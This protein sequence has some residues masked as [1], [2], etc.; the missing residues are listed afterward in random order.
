MKKTM[1]FSLFLFCL[2][3]SAI[4][5]SESGCLCSNPNNKGNYYPFNAFKNIYCYFL[6]GDF[7]HGSNMSRQ[8]HNTSD[9]ADNWPLLTSLLK[10]WDAICQERYAQAQ[11]YLDAAERTLSGYQKGNNKSKKEYNFLLTKGYLGCATGI[12]SNLEVQLEGK[13]PL[14]IQKLKELDNRKQALE[15][16]I[17]PTLERDSAALAREIDSLRQMKQKIEAFL[18]QPSEKLGSEIKKLNA[19]N[20]SLAREVAAREN[21]LRSVRKEL[22]AEKQ[23]V[24]QLDQEMNGLSKKDSS[25]IA[26]DYYRLLAER[27]SLGNIVISQWQVIAFQQE[28]IKRLFSP[29]TL[30]AAA[31]TVFF[32]SNSYKVSSKGLRR[33]EN[34]ARQIAARPNC[35]VLLI[36]FADSRGNEGFNKRLA[37]YRLDEVRYM[38]YKNGVNIMKIATDNFG[39]TGMDS[40]L[41]SRRVEIYVICDD[42]EA[43]PA[44]KVKARP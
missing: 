2:T 16:A 17:I 31:D 4:E 32:A 8:L 26:R 21:E 1:L 6:K 23:K 24:A 27:D 38:L 35:K 33:L 9:R 25:G 10:A 37:G 36:G 12:L 29:P 18:N 20:D 7:T 13:V 5:A 41:K 11:A 40:S 39:K 34:L 19:R 14:V 42:S 22:Q 43:N 3:P 30:P 44:Q 15:G 28:E